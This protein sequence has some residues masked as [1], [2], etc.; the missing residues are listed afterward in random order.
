MINLLL[1][2]I[3]AG[4]VF[5]TSV[6]FLDVENT[7]KEYFIIISTTILFI[8]CFSTRKGF[9]KIIESLSSRLFLNGVSLICLFTTV[10][11]LLQY[12]GIIPSHHSAFPITGTFEN[13][14]GFAAVQAALFPFVI[15][16]SFDR[17][18]GKALHL[19][20]VTVSIMC[21]ISVVLSGSRSG[22]LA[23][24]VSFFVVMAFNETIVSYLKSHRWLWIPL[25]P[26]IVFSFILLYQLKQDSADGRIFIWSRCFEM[27]KER[28]FC[29]Y[30]YYGFH[31]YYMSA[32]AD[33]FRLN[34]DS[35]FAMLADNVSHPFNEY[36]KLT[37]CFGLVGL[38]GALFMLVWI[39]RRLLISQ[40][41]TKVLGLS[42]VASIFIMCL[43]SYPFRYAVV[44]LLSV[45][46]ILPAFVE[47]GNTE[48]LLPRRVRT[49]ISTCFVLYL[50]TILTGMYF[51]MKWKEISK[52]ALIG[53]TKLMLKYYEG[54]PSFVKRNPLFLYN[55]AAELNYSGQYEESL[56]LIKLC[57][58]KWNDY[59]VQILKANNYA[60]LHDKENS[61][62]SYN[63]AMNMIPCRFEPLLGEMLVYMEFNDTINVLRV[64]N[65]INEKPIKVRSDRVS[66]IV[67]RSQ[68]VL[69]N[70]E[71]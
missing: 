13:P 51:D 26:L 35:P 58:K 49:V 65:E 24:C 6:L 16:G 36:I 22:F 41:Q 60:C 32:Q 34:P 39:I 54:M 2:L 38:F 25:I 12:C 20:S 45:F 15:N 7:G 47:S 52:R 5:I 66:F 11:G 29:G 71:Q 62:Q 64:A 28:P 31:R 67:E 61:I 30:G 10:H 48:I 27:I 40:S 46:V 43:F 9:N 57:E 21:F 19:S 50:A 68:Q 23:L 17:K 63:Q 37:I 3:L 59:D 4:G 1:L 69:S 18:G 53:Q 33:F 70:Y 42:Y 55:Y 44:W 14:A 56:S 8:I